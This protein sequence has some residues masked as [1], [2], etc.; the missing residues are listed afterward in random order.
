MTSSQMSSVVFIMQNLILPLN[1][2]KI[3]STDNGIK[4]KSGTSQ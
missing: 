3:F 1:Y 2:K 4:E